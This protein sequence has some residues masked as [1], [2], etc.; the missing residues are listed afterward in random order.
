MLLGIQ[1]LGVLFGMFMLYLTFIYGKRKEFNT[2]EGTIW[3]IAWIL[4]IFLAILPRSLD[5]LVKDI[6][7]VSRT[8]DFL[9]ILGFM[10]VLGVTF[11]NYYL[12]KKTQKKLENLVRNIAIEKK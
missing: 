2:T 7:S 11:Y 6:L 9:I 8:M 1:I 4:F 3:I 5:F 12:L 10:F